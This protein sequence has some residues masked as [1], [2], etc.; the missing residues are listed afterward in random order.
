MRKKLAT[1]LGEATTV[2]PLRVGTMTVENH[3]GRLAF[4]GDK[5]FLFAVSQGATDGDLEWNLRNYT[6]YTWTEFRRHVRNA[7]RK[8]G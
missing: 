2:A 1:I 4:Y 8:R 3:G 5:W 6:E 7:L